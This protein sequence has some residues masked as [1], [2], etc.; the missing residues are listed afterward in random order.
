MHALLEGTAILTME[1]DRSCAV[2][3]QES[4]AR[5]LPSEQPLPRRR[6]ESTASNLQIRGQADVTRLR[7]C[8]RVPRG[9]ESA[10]NNE[11]ILKMHFQP[12]SD[13]HTINSDHR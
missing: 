9:F 3:E 10:D 6:V 1:Q 13:A 7:I 8:R 2:R 11:N 4:W 12:S 5:R